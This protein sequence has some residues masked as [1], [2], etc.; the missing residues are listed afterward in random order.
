MLVF[1]AQKSIIDLPTKK[2]PA[3]FKI[4]YSK[5]FIGFFDE[6]TFYDLEEAINHANSKDFPFTIFDYDQNATIVYTS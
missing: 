5:L 4:L 6:K 2:E 1:Y 3:M